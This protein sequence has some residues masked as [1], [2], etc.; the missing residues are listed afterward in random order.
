[1]GK[2]ASKAAP[3]KVIYRRSLRKFSPPVN[4]TN[5]LATPASA[6]SGTRE[7]SLRLAE[8]ARRITNLEFAAA[9][10]R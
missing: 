2:V 1:M 4:V 10:V 9:R 3:I 7:S 6:D 5:V 8:F